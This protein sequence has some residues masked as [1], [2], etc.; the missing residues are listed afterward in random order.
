MAQNERIVLMQKQG[1][2]ENVRNVLEPTI[3]IDIGAQSQ[4]RRI[5]DALIESCAEKT[6]PATTIADIV[7]R[8]SISRTTFYKRFEDK[9]ECF[10]AALD[11][12]AEELRAAAAGSH[13][14]ADSPPDAVRKATAAMLELM[15][16]KPAL[17]Q[18]ILGEA[19]AV[20]PAAVERYR[21]TLIE[22]IEHLWDTAGEARGSHSDPHLAFGRAQVL[23]FNLVATARTDELPDLLPEIVYIS[24]LPFAGHE[25]AKGQAQLAAR[26]AGSH[27]V[28]QRIDG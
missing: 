26:G 14:S 18:L 28:R 6:Y 12:C 7:R 4:R 2:S 1:S 10:D 27:Y 19:A 23:I 25:V 15:A 5:V 21:T 16:A 13:S 3:P 8:A 22:A 24:L 17:A 20:E 9:R 11:C